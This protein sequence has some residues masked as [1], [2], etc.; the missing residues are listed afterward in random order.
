[1]CDVNEGQ[2]D[3]GVCLS[4]K[5]S[6]R[7]LIS[8]WCESTLPPLLTPCGPTKA[9]PSQLRPNNKVDAKLLAFSPA[10]LN[11]EEVDLKVCPGS[12]KLFLYGLL[13]CLSTHK[14]Q[15]FVVISELNINT[16]STFLCHFLSNI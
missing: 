16:G 7:I 13:V 10:P 9:L 12:V 14:E 5:N 4:S 1:M 15:F 3:V 6:R 8:A 11:T 2:K